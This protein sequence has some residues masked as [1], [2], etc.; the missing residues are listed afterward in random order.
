LIYNYFSRD[1]PKYKWGVHVN[2]PPDSPE[3]LVEI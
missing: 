2:I 3:F 1:I